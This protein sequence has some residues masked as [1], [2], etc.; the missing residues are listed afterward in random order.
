M[1]ESQASELL[2]TDLSKYENFVHKHFPNVDENKHAALVSFAYNLGTGALEKS[3]LAKHVKE[4]NYKAAANEFSKWTHAG[5]KVLPGLVTR[6]NE[7]REL[8]CKSGC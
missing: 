8:F 3:T 4:G 2:R 6:R 5:G 7:E 1:N